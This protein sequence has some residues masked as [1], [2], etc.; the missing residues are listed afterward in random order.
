MDSF[1]QLWITE[2]KETRIYETNSNRN[3]AMPE[4][5]LQEYAIREGGETFRLFKDGDWKYMSDEGIQI[6]YIPEEKQ[7]VFSITGLENQIMTTSPAEILSR[8]KA[9]IATLQ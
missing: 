8:V 9:K 5:T 6:E 3:K 1:S 7:Y 2:G 4:A